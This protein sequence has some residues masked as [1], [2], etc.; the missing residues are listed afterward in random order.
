MFFKLDMLIQKAIRTHMMIY[1]LNNKETE[2]LLVS[3]G[4][5]APQ[6]AT[7]PL[8]SLIPTHPLQ[9]GFRFHSNISPFPPQPLA[10]SRQGQ[11]PLRWN[12]YRGCFEA[13]EEPRG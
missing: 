5:Q 6:G 12:K 4:M 9:I 1:E 2:K 13:G 3:S 8:A 10:A 7:C 11:P